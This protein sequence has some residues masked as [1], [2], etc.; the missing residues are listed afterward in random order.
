MTDQ[1]AVPDLPRQ[2]RDLWA[3]SGE[4]PEALR[5]ALQACLSVAPPDATPQEVLATTLARLGYLPDEAQHTA[6]K[7]MQTKPQY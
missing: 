4:Q 6:A 2:L 7:I 3:R 5:D 1:P